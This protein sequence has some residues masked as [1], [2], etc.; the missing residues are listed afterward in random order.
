MAVSRG[1]VKMKIQSI[2]I[3]KVNR[4]S[5]ILKPTV[6]GCLKDTPSINITKG[7]MHSCVYCYARGFT[8]APP[9]GKIYLYQNLPEM[10]EKELDKKKKLPNWVSFSTASDAFQNVDEILEITYRTMKLL[11][12]RGIG[13]SFL[14][15]GFIPSDFI[16]LFKKYISLSS[17]YKGIRA[18]IGLVSLSEDFRTFFEPYTTSTFQRLL[19]IRKLIN[20][21]IDVAVRIDPIIPGITDSQ[22]S[23]Q[24]LLKRLEKEGIKNISISFLV[25]RPTIMNFFSEL[26]SN[27]AQNILKY[28]HG[29]P[30]QSVI[31][32][33]KTKLLPK[34]MRQSIYSQIKKIARNY[35]ID[36]KIC[37]CKNPDLPWEFCSPWIEKRETVERQIS[38][39]E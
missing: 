31:T 11:L 17:L 24:H 28:Y 10:L 15:K 14:T 13:I 22:I 19:N 32:S 4:K 36:C 7:C 37:G 18:K 6:F 3:I 23:I 29:Q 16:E 25:M 35:G 5:Q 9:K 26:P 27:I 2:K 33:A 39:L 30:W 20:A 21:G 38:L 34:N 8:D 12:E 1:R